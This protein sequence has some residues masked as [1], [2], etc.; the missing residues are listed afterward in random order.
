MPLLHLYR[1]CVNNVIVTFDLQKGVS[2]FEALL[3]NSYVH[4]HVSVIIDVN[5]LVH[6]IHNFVMSLYQTLILNVC[7]HQRGEKAQ[8]SH[9]V[10]CIDKLGQ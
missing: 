9:R 6:V 3:T 10:S 2:K 4:A 5:P 1:T 7:K 8:G